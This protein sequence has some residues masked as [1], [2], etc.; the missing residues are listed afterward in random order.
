MRLA[1]GGHRRV[2]RLYALSSPSAR[3]CYTQLLSRVDTFPCMC[4]LRVLV[5]GVFPEKIGNGNGPD[6]KYDFRGKTILLR[7]DITFPRN[8]DAKAG[9]QQ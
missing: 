9:L 3:V 4:L 7:R 8:L 2:A 5:K 1:L 6:V